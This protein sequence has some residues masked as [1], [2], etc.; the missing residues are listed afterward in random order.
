M[1]CVNFT[2]KSQFFVVKIF[3]ILTCAMFLL[4]RPSV[5]FAFGISPG[6]VVVEKMLADTTVDSMIM[7]S[8]ARPEKEAYVSILIDGPQ[9]DAIQA[10]SEL[11][12]PAGIQQVPFPFTISSVG[13]PLFQDFLV[14]IRFTLKPDE[15]DTQGAGMKLELVAKVLFSVT[16][17]P[18]NTLTTNQV[19]H[20]VSAEAGK[21]KVYVPLVNTG[22]VQTRPSSMQIT[23]YKQKTF[24]KVRVLQLNQ[25][26]FPVAAPFSQQHA[27]VDLVHH[28][29]T[30]N[31]L[32]ESEI[33][34]NGKVI[35]QSP[36][37]PIQL[38]EG[39]FRITTLIRQRY[40]QMFLVVFVLSGIG[41]VWFFNRKQRFK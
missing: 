40:I 19:N 21:L 6:Q 18:I 4:A 38:I 39:P 36:R 27:Y 24:K 1:N 26:D 31:Y 2:K 5:S 35:F 37:V 7:L 34:H 41:L 33:V 32:I 15:T 17:E 3:L 14:T 8:R 22:N 30:G 9:K 29:A 10:P 23:L 11:I 16:D 25:D 12:L 13:L 28:L 20:F